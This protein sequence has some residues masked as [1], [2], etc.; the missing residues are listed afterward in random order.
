M[1]F[2]AR[3]LAG[4]EELIQV[5]AEVSEPGVFDREF[6]ALADAA[7]EHPRARQRLLVANADALPAKAPANVVVQPAWA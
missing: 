5:C 7:K 6:R 1:D 4:G 3:P 2:L